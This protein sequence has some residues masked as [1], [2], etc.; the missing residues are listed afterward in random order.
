[1][2]HWLAEV[3]LIGC[4]IPGFAFAQSAVFLDANP[5]SGYQGATLVE[6]A[7]SGQEIV[8]EVVGREIEGVSGFSAQINFDATQLS[9]D[10]FV[11]GDAIPDFTGLN[12]AE[13]S[14]RVVIGGAS[15]RGVASA[16]KGQLGV[17]RFRVLDGFTSD[18]TISLGTVSISAQGATANVDG[19]SQV[20]IGPA[21]AEGLVLDADLTPGHQGGVSVLDATVGDVVEVE[22]Y[23]RSLM[24]VTGFSAVLNFDSAQLAFDG[25]S[26]GAVIP[27]LTGLKAD[28]AS[29]SVEIG[30]ASVTGAAKVQADRL[31]TV[32]FKIQTGFTGQTS[33][34]LVSGQLVIG[35]DASPFQSNIAIAITGA[36]GGGTVAKTPDFNGNGKVD[37]PDFLLFAGAFGKNQNSAD[38]DA[39]LDLDDSGDIGFSDFL[40]FAQAFGKDVGG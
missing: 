36:A 33:I 1:M 31:G 25:F 16:T 13:E 10:G 40:Q 39:R 8:V 23:G 21:I 7:Q 12:I 3:F 9:F 19:T 17:V 35:A 28:V 14:G 34:Q 11:S 32:R 37:F 2:R 22:V 38:F 18:A 4:L 20:V 27:G 29:G 24:G 5:A 15:V 26:A 6:G 30:G